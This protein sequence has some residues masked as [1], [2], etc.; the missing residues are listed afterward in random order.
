MP[1]VSPSSGHDLSTL[2]SLG[3]FDTT[4]TGAEREVRDDL[5]GA[6]SGQVQLAQSH[7]IDPAG[8]AAKKM[9]TL[10]TG[11]AALLLFTPKVPARSVTVEISLDGV[12]RDTVELDDPTQIPRSDMAITGNREDVVYT[13]KAWTTQ[14]PWDVMKKGLS[15]K[16]TTD[17]G[18]TGVLA[19]DGFEFAAPKELILSSIELGMLTDAPTSSDH[20]L[21]NEPEK[22][23]SDYFQTMPIARMVVASY[24]KVELDKV[25]VN[26]GGVGTIYTD[27]S[28]STGGVYDGDMREDVGKAQVST[29]INLANFGTSSSRMNQ[30]Q[31]GT[32]NQRI[33]HH[34]A[35]LYAN[36]VQAHGLSGGNGMA[37]LYSSRGNEL[38]HE[39]G[40]SYGLGHYPGTNNSATGDAKVINASQHSESG[41]GYIAY[42]DRMRSNLAGGSAFT[43]AGFE[44]GAGYFVQNYQGIYNYNRDAMAGGWVTSTLSQYTHYTGYSADIIQR[45]LTTV[46]P[47]LRYPSG[48]RDWDATT[49][50]YVDAKVIRPT[51]S[52]PR[53]SKVGVPVFTLLGG[54]N[55]S[56]ESHSLMYPAF[57][58][59]YGNVFTPAAGAVDTTQVNATRSCWI[60]VSFR[61]GHEEDTAL[62][63]TDGVKQFNVNVDQAD[64]PTG[65]SIHC[66][67]DGVTRQL[68]DAITIATD[69]PAMAPVVVIGEDEGYSALRAVEI[70][71]LDAS[72]QKL[73]GVEVPVLQG[74]AAVQLSS[75]GTD[76]SGL[77]ASSLAV[78]ERI[79][80]QQ[81]AAG[82]VET[83]V[84]QNA[85]AL[86][87]G[88]P[89]TKATLVDLLT[90]NGMTE[91]DGGVV[92]T[93]TRLTVDAG[94]CLTV[95]DVGGEN[96]VVATDNSAGCSDV[97]NQRWS[98]DLRGAIHNAALPGLC[99]TA[100]TPATLTSCS[101]TTGSQVWT[102]ENDGHLKSATSSY[103]DLYKHK[104]PATPGMYGRTDG[105]NQKWLGLTVSRN[106]AL[107][108]LA[109]STLALLHT[110]DLK[111][112]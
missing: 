11:R 7:T 92:P 68:G 47:D 40:H 104:S 90:A 72:L 82:A 58:S 69:L 87:A 34:S 35:G 3:F 30:S 100:A 9:P 37:T 48:Y 109:P 18:E 46:V 78:V 53:P 10:V 73:V 33:I 111:V 99:L 71:E 107:V 4:S 66:R 13:R 44:V 5:A 106:P 70:V 63:A 101:R 79:R 26:A 94:R 75:W 105:A 67:T 32:F 28:S 110:L 60:T 83:F 98:M 52:S 93:G 64:Q 42:R 84:R 74:T 56:N 21:L 108:T 89:T 41:W 86:A 103:L 16:F 15:L 65:A 88:D 29:G 14:L 62:L 81:A 20:Y 55:P 59:N 61:D 38:S 39:L 51:F 6:L 36:G 54:Y 8:N 97:E 12:V 91:S 24:E 25:I 23:G 19:A 57:R 80:A 96:R 102:L 50:T 27:A 1:P 49:G 85:S 112:S 95:E 45:S 2:P 22:A 77:S 31:P 43:P 17:T 76:L